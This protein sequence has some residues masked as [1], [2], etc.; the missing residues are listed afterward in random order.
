MSEKNMTGPRCG[1][2]NLKWAPHHVVGCSDCGWE[3]SQGNMFTPAPA[4]PV[5]EIRIKAE[6]A[7]DVVG[8]D[9]VAEMLYVSCGC[10]ECPCNYGPTDEWLP[11][12]C[13]LQDECPNPKDKL[14]CWKQYIKH[15]A[16]RP[17]YLRGAHER[18]EPV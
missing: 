14:G 10:D 15:F 6:P 13:D 8:L 1:G 9:V 2:T 18:E 16:E 17:E 11:E 12:V 3:G 7:A 5:S 4:I